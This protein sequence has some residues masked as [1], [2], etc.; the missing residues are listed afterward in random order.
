MPEGYNNNH[1]LPSPYKGEACPLV[2]EPG[3]SSQQKIQI[4]TRPHPH[5]LHYIDDIIVN[6]Q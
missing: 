2:L 4:T 6:L 1:N 5:G 3:S